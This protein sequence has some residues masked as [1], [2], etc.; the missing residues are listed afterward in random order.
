MNA[1]SKTRRR[2]PI[3]FSRL[4][5]GSKFRIAA[6]PTRTPPIYRSTDLRVYE[7]KAES[8]SVDTGDKD[9]FII[10]YPDDLVEPLTRGKGTR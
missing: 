2:Y 1:N 4:E 5:V 6:E 3:R 10:L 8:F 7:K 9:H